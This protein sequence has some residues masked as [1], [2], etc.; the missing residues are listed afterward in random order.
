MPSL[1]S[2]VNQIWFLPQQ[3]YRNKK[4]LHI[5]IKRFFISFVNKHTSFTGVVNKFDV[6]SLMASDSFV[7][8]INFIKNLMFFVK[9]VVKKNYQALVITKP[10]ETKLTNLKTRVTTIKKHY[11]KIF[12]TREMIR[13]FYGSSSA[14]FR[15]FTHENLL[16]YNMPESL[17][18]FQKKHTHQGTQSNGLIRIFF[19]CPMKRKNK[20]MILNFKFHGGMKHKKKTVEKNSMKIR[21]KIMRNGN[22]KT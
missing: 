19:I 16:K 4:K 20:T 17:V 8:N 15:I 1:S 3:K 11:N 22:G 12:R 6:T 13:D 21:K 9:A 18:N 14:V 7:F 10:G 5:I 2:Y